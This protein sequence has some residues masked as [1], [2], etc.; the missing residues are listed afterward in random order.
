MSTSKASKAGYSNFRDP[1]G[2]LIRMLKSKNKAAYFTIFR[3]GLSIGLTPVDILLSLFEG[4]MSKLGK[5]SDLPLILILGGSR[6]GTT[7][8]YQTLV[9]YLPV[10]YFNN[11]GVSFPRSPITSSKLFNRLVQKRE[12]KKDFNNYFGSVSGFDGPND[13]FHIWN[14]WFGEDR[15]NVPN[16]LSDDTM[17]DLNEFLHTWHSVHQK[18]LLNKNNRNSLSI[19][20]FE[21]AYDQNVYY[22]EIR[23]DPVYVIQSIILS[24][25]EI[26]GDKRLAWGLASK[27]STD[28]QNPYAYIDDICKQV[29]DV[30]QKISEGRRLID[31][32]RY[33][34]FS[35]GS[36][37]SHP[38]EIVQS[39]SQAIWGKKLPIEGIKDLQPFKN[40]NNMRLPKEEFERIIQSVKDKYGENYNEL[41]VVTH[42][43]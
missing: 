19:P 41:E 36:F 25:L 12:K 42:S 17:N 18:P 20:F 8:L 33:V 13:G 28:Q 22:I 11:L 32:G 24:R 1:K 14:R 6:S 30:E 40:T 29:F 26:Q 27:D 37:C 4:R 10:S 39:C 34:K 31:P 3:E 5:E 2:L 16:K 38:K 43:A 7:L 35:Y 15:N 21:K 23:R 9:Q